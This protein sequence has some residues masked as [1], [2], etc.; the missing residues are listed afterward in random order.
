MGIPPKLRAEPD[1]QLPSPRLQDGCACHKQPLLNGKPFDPKEHAKELE[2]AGL[3]AKHKK[4]AGHFRPTFK[5]PGKG[6][7][8]GGTIVFPHF[9]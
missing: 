1:A 7:E 4:L 2:E 5:P 3:I 8:K 9:G 6:T